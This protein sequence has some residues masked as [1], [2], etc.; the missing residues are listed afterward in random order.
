MRGKKMK[1]NV[2]VLE[3]VKKVSDDQLSDLRFKFSQNMS[4]DR[5]EICEVLQKDREVDRWLQKANSAEEF[6]DML[7]VIRDQ[8]NQEYSTR[9]KPSDKKRK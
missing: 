8:V 9:E 3:Y 2:A 6:F 5:A 7:D 4:G 1:A